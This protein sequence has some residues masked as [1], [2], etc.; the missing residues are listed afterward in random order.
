MV[1]LAGDLFHD[2]KP[3]RRALQRC[4]EAPVLRDHCLG[5]REVVSDQTANFHDKYKSVNYEDSN[6]NVQ[7]PVFSIHG[8]HDD[9]AGDGHIRDERLHRALERKEVSVARPSK[10]TDQW[11][12]RGAGDGKKGYIKESQLPS[13]MDIVV[14]GHEHKCEIGSGAGTE[15]VGNNFV[16]LQPGS[17]V[18]TSLVEGE[19]E[20]KHVGLLEVRGDQWKFTALPLETVRPFILKDVVEAA[21]LELR[22][23]H[24]T[25]ALT[26]AAENRAKFPL[27][28]LRVDYSGYA[29]CNPQRFGQRFV[30]KAR[31]KA[32]AAA[33]AEARD[34]GTYD[35]GEP[36]DART[37]I[38]SFVGAPPRVSR[39][40][41]ANLG[42]SR[43][44]SAREFLQ[45]GSKEQLRLLAE[46]ELNTAVFEGYVEKENKSAISAAAKE[47]FIEDMLAKQPHRTAPAAGAASSSAAGGGASAPPAS[48][49]LSDAPD[50]SDDDAPAPPLPPPPPSPS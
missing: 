40:I 16:V 26:K 9:P 8:N 33:A 47:T 44:I 2:N 38:Q 34:E 41:S 31:K 20:D 25:T 27:V 1:L 19:S 46:H 32:E 49:A 11:H 3:S 6:Y 36:D 21:I 12:E 48:S 28:R 42:E 23:R 10:D 13:C 45:K 15:A 18:A 22:E 29:T 37:Q 35:G 4:M 30:D 39:R 14:W 43:R 7:L 5:Q 24:T 17:T 50:D